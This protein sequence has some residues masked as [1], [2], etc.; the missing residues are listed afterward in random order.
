MLAFKKISNGNSF[1]R[2]IYEV[3]R[4][5]ENTNN[6]AFH[7]L[8]SLMRKMESKTVVVEDINPNDEKIIIEEREALCR[9][10]DYDIEMQ[11]FRLSF[12]RE[13]IS[14]EEE[15]KKLNGES[16]FLA[17]A[18]IIDFKE[19]GK[20][21]SY[22]FNAIVS[23]PRMKIK[24]DEAS[25]IFIPIVNNYIH[26]ARN[27]DCQINCSNSNK[28]TYK[29]F[30]TYFCQQNTFTS[31]CAHAAL[32]I[33]IN[34]CGG[35]MTTEQLNK[36]LGID[37]KAKK[38]RDIEIKNSAVEGFL[39]SRNFSTIA[40]DFFDE[41]S[42]M[43]SF[44]YSEYLYRHI[45]SR[46]PCLLIL[47]T[48]DVEEDHIVSVIGHTWNTDLWKPEAEMIYG[49]GTYIKNVIKVEDKDGNILC[50][51]EYRPAAVWVDHL[52]IHDDNFGMYSCLTVDLLRRITPL[53]LD[54]SFRA[55]QAIIIKPEKVNIPA[56]E[57]EK[58]SI[59]AMIDNISNLWALGS[60]DNEANFW[61]KELLL[62][63]SGS[64]APLV[65]RTLLI[66]KESYH[67]S[68]DLSDFRKNSLSETEKRQIIEDLPEKFWLTEVTLPDL[69][70][71]NKTKLV[72]IF[73]TSNGDRY[74]RK[75]NWIQTRLP[76]FLI[77]KSESQPV[78]LDVSSHYPLFRFKE[79][80]EV[81]E[82]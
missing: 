62:S 44:D 46:H 71:A 54:P 76:G 22:V 23:I 20:W 81:C 67:Q 7:R 61:I 58:N 60:P 1:F 32:S 69:Y 18:T 31:V 78:P 35:F 26:S 36:Y 42:R 16:A 37:H 13:D 34:N 40:V 43:P 74:N 63:L 10:F 55:K 65:V 14:N 82:W 80:C 19:N 5:S 11:I 52:L 15:L 17:N 59:I 53:N 68:L 4:A 51:S 39:R 79:N 8:C 9:Y 21:H 29:I 2:F 70:T 38:L 3:W 12:C 33:T 66:R 27:F 77:K 75:E 28:Y 49:G 45:E 30:G 56:E 25:Y 24:K 57:A 50:K 72:D 6:R 73:H 48:Q 47:S 64:S 41:I